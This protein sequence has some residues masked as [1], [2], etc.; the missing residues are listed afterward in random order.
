MSTLP[1]LPASPPQLLRICVRFA[2]HYP[3]YY[4]A[5]PVTAQLI[6]QRFAL[7]SDPVISIDDQIGPEL[8]PFPC[9]PLYQ[10]K[11]Q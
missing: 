5:D 11:G 7:L 4:T 8:K 6:S 2:G 1:D 3:L 10:Q 9:L